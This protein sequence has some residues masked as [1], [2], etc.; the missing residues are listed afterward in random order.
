MIP[1]TPPEVNKKSKEE[2]NAASN[3]F[4]S[5]LE[6]QIEQ[7]KE[8]GFTIGKTALVVGG[9]AFAGYILVDLFTG[10]EKKKKGII[11]LDAN[12]HIEKKSKKDPWIIAS[13]KGYILAFL[14]GIARE[15]IVEALEE[16][17][18]N[19]QADLRQNN[20]G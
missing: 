7:I 3:K 1:V 18:K 2:L 11:Q 20:K 13:I 6:N 16:I 19:E 4:K 15:K 12:N 14:I 9:I 8:R 17:N 10:K 5:A